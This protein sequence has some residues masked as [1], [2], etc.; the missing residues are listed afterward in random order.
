MMPSMTRLLNV[1]AIWGEVKIF[2]IIL[3]AVLF[4]EAPQFL[5]TRKLY[6]T[7][8]VDIHVPPARLLT[9]LPLL[10]LADP[11]VGQGAVREFENFGQMGWPPS[12][13]HV[14]M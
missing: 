14:A 8:T 10:E 11:A 7:R 1:S 9:V 12:Y 13:L 5:P 3:K 6:S 2:R 4:K